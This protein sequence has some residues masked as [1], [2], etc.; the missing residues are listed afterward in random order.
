MRPATA[1]VTVPAMFSPPVASAGPRTPPKARLPKDI[2]DVLTAMV[3]GLPGDEQ[4]VDFGAKRT[5][6]EPRLQKA[7]RVH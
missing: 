3:R 7:L 5:L 1:S 4:P 2:R 6:T